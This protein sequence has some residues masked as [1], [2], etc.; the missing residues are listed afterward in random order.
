MRRTSLHTPPLRGFLTVL[1]LLLTSCSPAPEDGASATS[2]G[3]SATDSS[4]GVTGSD[5]GGTT[6][7]PPDVD[8]ATASPRESDSPRESVEVTTARAAAGVLWHQDL[9]PASAPV[10][11]D[12]T[13]VLYTVGDRALRITGVDPQD[14]AVLWSNAATPSLRPRGQGLVVQS[15]EDHVVHLAPSTSAPDGLGAAQVIVRDPESGQ[16]QHASTVPL[17]HADLPGACPHDATQV[18][19]TVNVDG[20]WQLQ[21]LTPDDR[22][23]DIPTS[24]AGVPGWV[25]IGPLGLAR[26]AA[27]GTHVGRV[28]GGELLWQIDTTEVFGSGQ[29][30]DTGWI[31]HDVD[32]EVLAGTVGLALGSPEDGDIWDLTD[33]RS[34]GLDA[35]TGTTL[36]EVLSVSTF[37][38]TDLTSA[39]DDP[40]LVCRWNAGTA[41]VSGDRLHYLDLDADLLR[42][43]PH[44]GEVLWSVPLGATVD[45]GEPGSPRPQPISPEEVAVA[46]SSGVIII[47]VQTGAH[48]A[49]T[50]A[51]AVWLEDTELVDVQDTGGD[52]QVLASGR[53]VV[54]D[55]LGRA[56]DHVTWPLPPQ[57]GV[58]VDDGAIRIVPRPEGLTAY[59]S[60]S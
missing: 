34:V 17:S 43:E 8:Q 56:T 1:A 12:D 49:A 27:D 24:G 15:V 31:F 7:A 50:E 23:T 57:V 2:S 11:L 28:D 45:D 29:S 20:S 5:S 48:R 4:A 59:I 58:D 46:T 22:F 21:G 32:G 35:A 41:E 9:V 3:Q 25:G 52:D 55:G 33:Y 14:G 37:C 47:N 19:A 36:W 40:L 42:L 54:H 6:A 53:Y 30:T 16:E 51:D 60:G 39:D 26:L 13:L 18:C 10:L 44:T 38:D